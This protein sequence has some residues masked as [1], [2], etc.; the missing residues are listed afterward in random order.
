MHKAENFKHRARAVVALVAAGLL[1]AGCAWWS[2]EARET[3]KKRGCP[4]AGILTD[5]AQLTEYAGPGRDITDVA[6]RWE[7][8]DAAARCT[9]DGNVVNVEYGFSVEAA[10]GPAATQAR[11]T[12]P[13]FIALTTADER[14]VEKR[15]IDVT[16]EFRN[17]ERRVTYAKTFDDIAFDVGE[18]DGR[19]YTIIIG[20]QLTPEQLEE[21][22][23]R[24]AL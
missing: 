23:R 13:V 10:L 24:A 1:A 11:R 17:G 5:A 8:I 16:A 18:G 3:V 9:Y 12:V 21:N 6:Y 7:L 22:R 14:I 19:F 20:F 15:V 2:G 4:T